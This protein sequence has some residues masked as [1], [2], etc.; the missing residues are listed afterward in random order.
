MKSKLLIPGLLG[1]VTL[2][3]LFYW[4]AIRPSNIKHECYLKTIKK[5]KDL[6]SISGVNTFYEFCLHDKG[7]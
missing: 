6:G 7:L 1:L 5:S 4:Y 2:I 3:T